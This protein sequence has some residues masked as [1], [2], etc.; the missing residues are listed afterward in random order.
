MLC[1][2]SSRATW[3]Q[4]DFICPAMLSYSA[5]S[6]GLRSTSGGGLGSCGIC[7]MHRQCQ[8]STPEVASK[9]CS[10]EQSRLQYPGKM[11]SSLS[12]VHGII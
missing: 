2:R 7:G 10:A 8:H 6:V 11:C 4:D 12:V 3:W 5:S 9:Q 1:T